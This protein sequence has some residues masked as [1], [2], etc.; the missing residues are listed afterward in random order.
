MLAFEDVMV[1][2]NEFN[3]PVGQLVN[4][5]RGAKLPELITMQGK[6]C[7]LELLNIE[8]HADSLFEN[9]S[10]D[11]KGESW[12]YLPYGPFENKTT[13]RIWLK[14]KVAELDTRLYVILNNN[15]P[16]GIAGYLRINLEHG[17]IEVGH[18]HYS[19]LLQQTSAATEAMY[20]MMCYAFDD[21]GYRRYE[22]K[23]NSLNQASHN[24]ALR[25]GFKF[26]GIFRQNHVFKNR[27]RDTTWFSIIDSEWLPIKQRFQRWLDSSNFDK[28]H[29]QIKR[30]NEI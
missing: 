26:E 22:W 6:F 8:N 10:I 4:N 30:L 2:K 5:W 23:C 25:L 7:V 14:E 1:E 16:I 29:K 28:N 24:A 27:N 11:N 17:V 3:Q 18:L 12:T 20:L 19:K 21:L 9:L 15:N 13:F